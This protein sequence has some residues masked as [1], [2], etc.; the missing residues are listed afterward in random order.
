MMLSFL[1]MVE[2]LLAKPGERRRDG[3]T[4]APFAE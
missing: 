2:T 4:V 3:N 1:V